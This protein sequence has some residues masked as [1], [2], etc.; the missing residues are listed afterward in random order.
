[1]DLER[2]IEAKQVS[3]LNTGSSLRA[4]LRE[5]PPVTRS[6]CYAA[7]APSH[8][9]IDGKVKRHLETAS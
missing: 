5:S 9:L 4:G 7:V 3:T 6:V 2:R 1:M 8:Q